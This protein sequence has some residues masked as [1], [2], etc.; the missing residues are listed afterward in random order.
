[1]M[2]FGEAVKTCLRKFATVKGRA[3]R[4]EYWWFVL[5][6]TCVSW[7]FSFA[8]MVSPILSVIGTILS[9]IFTIPGLTALTRR[10]H[11]T[12]HSGW[13]VAIIALVYAIILIGGIMLIAPYISQIAD[14][15]D[16]DTMTVFAESMANAVSEHEVLSTVMVVC[17]LLYMLLWV[18][19]FIFAVMDSK[20]GTN[21]YGAS[22][23]Y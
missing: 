7:A 4:S 14:A 17:T 12:G 3:R 13:W 20:H 19:T 5:F 2:S 10:L 8:G 22:P 21:K 15:K 6:V 18:I 1:M 23:K 9:I 16:V 11:D